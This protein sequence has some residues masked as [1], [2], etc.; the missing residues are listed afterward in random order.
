MTSLDDVVK[1]RREA[2]IAVADEARG[3]EPAMGGLGG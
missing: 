3:E 2:M 1:G